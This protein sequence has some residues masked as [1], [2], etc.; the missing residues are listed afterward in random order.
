MGSRLD[1]HGWVLRRIQASAKGLRSS[2]LSDERVHAV[3]R[4][5]KEA[6]AGLRLLRDSI[7]ESE[8]RRNNHALRDV[9][10]ALRQVR[11]AKMLQEAGRRWKEAR[12]DRLVM[13]RLRSELARDCTQARRRLGM[14]APP[15]WRRH[16]PP[17]RECPP[18]RSARRC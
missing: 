2:P 6:R 3:R 18:I 7:G 5:L 14:R 10:G 12:Q 8:Y 1:V 15:P 16:R 17:R 11:D 9:A 4:H 13:R